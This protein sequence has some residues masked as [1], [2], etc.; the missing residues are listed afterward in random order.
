M[1]TDTVLLVTSDSDL[2]SSLTEALSA[3][4]IIVESA[5]SVERLLSSVERDWQVGGCTIVVDDTSLGS[6]GISVM[7]DLTARTNP[8]PIIALVRVGDVRLAVN[9]IRAGA[10][11]VVEKQGHSEHLMVSI[12]SSLISNGRAEDHR[13]AAIRHA[14]SGLTASERGVLS[15]TV[16]GFSNKEIARELDISL[17]TVAIRRAKLIEKLGASNRAQLIRFALEAGLCGHN[18]ETVPNGRPRAS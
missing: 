1:A 7:A 5:S 15:M 4:A 12:R 6:N 3:H 11:D 9:L 17:R 18:G 13:R 14:A 2:E 10:Y 16:A 8:T